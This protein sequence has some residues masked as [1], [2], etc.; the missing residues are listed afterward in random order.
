MSDWYRVL[1]TGGGTTTAVSVLKGLRLASDPSLHV[2][3]GDM[4]EECAGAH[5]GDEF[6][7]LPS[8]SDPDFC[9]K[10]IRLCREYRIKLVI[11]IIDHEFVGWSQVR[12]QLREYGCEVVISS[13]QALA[14]CREKDR[15]FRFFESRGIPTIQTWRVDE[16]ADP[17]TLPYPVYMKPRCGRASIDNYRADNLDEYRLF[18]GKVPDAIVQ[19]FTAGTEV[20]IDCL[21]DLSG[22]FLSACPRVRVQVKS[23]QSYRSRTFRD[24]ALEATAK[25]IVEALPI[26]GACNMQCFLTDDG[27]RFFEINARF[28]AGSVLSMQAGLNGPAALVAMARGQ[29]LPMLKPRTNVSMLRYWQEVFVENA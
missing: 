12:G 24:A 28:G 1:V 14:D 26:I 11:P 20:T 23:G 6:V 15:T 25:K 4:S 17:A 10:A 21:S 5:L 19:P 13:E 8:A 18:V 9:A 7:Q 22:R 29:T 27:P 2:V 3:L 16:I